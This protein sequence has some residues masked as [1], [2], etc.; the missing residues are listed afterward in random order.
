MPEPYATPNPELESALAPY[1]RDGFFFV[2]VGASD[3]MSNDP[4][5]PFMKKYGWRGLL[6]EPVPHTFEVLRT[7]YAQYPGMLFEN[8]LIASSP[9]KFYYFPEDYCRERSWAR[10]IGSLDAES[11]RWALAH[12]AKDSLFEGA[13]IEDL[14]LI[15]EADL[16]TMTFDELLAKHRIDRVDLI[17]LD[18]E[19]ADLEILE[20]IDLNRYGVRA[21]VVETRPHHHDN[22]IPRLLDAQG[23]EFVVAIDW[24]TDA[25]VRR[26]G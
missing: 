8:S 22:K 5:Y 13:K 2:N 15:A 9:R 7:N 21:V 18:T 24:A 12:I 6:V 17:N 11:T 4:I 14:D 26:G 10:Q 1:L 25:F 19:G 20:P 3:G 23:F 16:P